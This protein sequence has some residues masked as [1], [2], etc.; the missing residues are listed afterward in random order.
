MKAAFILSKLKNKKN[1]LLR[2]YQMQFKKLILWLA[3][4]I[5]SSPSFAQVTGLA[6]WDIYLDPGHSRKEN[7]GIYGYS[8]AEKNVRVSLNLREILLT[9]TDIDT[10]WSSRYDDNVLVSLSQR[11]DQANALGAA[12]YHS[13]HSDAGS[14]Q[15]N[16]TLLLW[17]QHSD[18]TEKNPPGGHAMS[19]IM[20]DILTRG[21]RIGTRGSIG[22]C[23]FYGCTFY[24]PYLHVNRESN[25]PS[26]LSEAGFHTSPVQNVLNMNAEWKRLE[27]YTFFWSILE[28]HGIQRPPVGIVTGIVFDVEKNRPL[29]GAHIRIDG[30]LGFEYTTDTWDSLFYMYTNDPELLHNGFYFI[31]GLPPLST[32]AVIVEAPDFHSDTTTVV[33][34]DT[35]FTFLDVDLISSLPPTVVSTIPEQNQTNVSILDDIVIN[36]SRRM[37]AASVES[38][39]TLTPPSNLSFAWEN[40]NRKL[41]IITDT[42]LNDTLYTLSISKDALDLFGHELDGDGNGI[43]GD[44][45]NLNFTTAPAD[46]TPPQIVSH[47]PPLNATGVENP[48]IINIEFDERIVE[49][50][51]TQNSIILED[52]ISHTPVTGTVKH[53]PVNDKSVLCF[54]PDV[55]LASNTEYLSRLQPGLQDIWGNTLQT[56]QI[57]NFT[58]GGFIFNVTGIDNFDSGLL[59]NWWQPQQSGS[60]TGIISTETSMGNN[61]Q[62]TNLLTGSSRSMRLSYGW[63][64]NANSWLIREYLSTGTPRNVTFDTSYLLQMYVFGDGSGN[65][66]RFAIDDNVPGGASNHEV[67]VWYTIDWTGWRLISWDL[68]NDPVGTWIGNG[69]L[70][71]TLRFDSIQLTYVQGAAESGSIYIDD[72]RLAKSVSVG[73]ADNGNLVF[74]QEFALFQNYPNPFNPETTIRY[75]VAQKPQHVKLFVYDVLGKVVAILVDEPKPAGIHEVRWDGKTSHGQNAGS[76]TYIYR[77]TIGEFSQARKMVLLR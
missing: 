6:G 54:F 44:N 10:V 50:S 11:T 36:F 61:S 17:G 46:V 39:T 42:L 37:N 4:F 16:S 2:G 19:D 70:E 58:T 24:G 75:T 7:M 49:S 51:V 71:G 12:W 27:A 9:Q 5:I 40:Q 20:V 29:N 72:L 18:G 62:F 3:L 15:S 14:P 8:E 21:M 52:A 64:V 69:I 60:T 23:S 38:N 25:M 35:F 65:Q 76:G 68:A 73:I 33:I 30:M 56:E 47:Y 43:G 26:E 74:P 55:V 34:S 59:T 53:Y 45:F 28:Y 32:I 41:T 31:E 48:P 22:D 13:I 77:I 67:S 66:I 1:N 57:F 63:D